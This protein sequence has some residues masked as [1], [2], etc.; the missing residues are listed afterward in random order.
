MV[1]EPQPTHELI[2]RHLEKH[3]L[4]A[5]MERAE[6]EHPGLMEALAQPQHVDVEQEE[7][8]RMLWGD[9]RDT[10]ELLN[11]CGGTAT[12]VLVTEGDPPA[13]APT[14]PYAMAA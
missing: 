2:R 7:A 13:V 14:P 4:T 9:A 11:H 12:S 3:G 1:T 6:K 8:H 10:G 5:I